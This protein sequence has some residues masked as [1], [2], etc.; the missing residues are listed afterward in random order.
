MNTKTYG[1]AYRAALKVAKNDNA[2]ERKAKDIAD[3]CGSIA[4]MVAD[5]SLTMQDVKKPDDPPMR[6]ALNAVT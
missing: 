2:D 4:A 6:A 3:A 1:T 5:G